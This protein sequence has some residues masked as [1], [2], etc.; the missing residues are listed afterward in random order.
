MTT[1]RMTDGK[2]G[3]WAL[4]KH[5]FLHESSDILIETGN[6]LREQ[7]S[8]MG[9]DKNRIY[10]T[11]GNNSRQASRILLRPVR[12]NGSYQLIAIGRTEILSRA[13]GA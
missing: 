1:R 13:L 4:R 8:A 7:R 11:A 5:H 2:I 10:G 9:H 6:W 12:H 3:R